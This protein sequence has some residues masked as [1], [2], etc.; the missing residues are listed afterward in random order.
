MKLVVVMAIELNF[1]KML[2]SKTFVVVYEDG[3]FNARALDKSI[4]ESKT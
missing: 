1:Y 3:Y 4:G 2:I